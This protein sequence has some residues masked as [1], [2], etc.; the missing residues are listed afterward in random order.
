MLTG[1]TELEVEN[2]CMSVGY[3]THKGG[4]PLSPMEVAQL[5]EK[6]RAHG[7]TT[8]QC[9]REI[10]ID[11][12]GIGRF[13][14][15]LNLPGKFQDIVSWGSGYGAIGFSCANEL[16]RL[17]DS[18]ALEDVAAAI[19]EHGF[20]SRETR[21]VVQLLERSSAGPQEAVQQV[22]RMRPMVEKRYVY[23]GSVIDRELSGWLEGRSQKER[24]KLL[25]DAA[26]GLDL[27]PVSARLGSVRFTVV[28]GQEFGSRLSEIG[29]DPLE[30]MI[31]AIMRQEM[32]DVESAR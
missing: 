13:R 29:G 22:I 2:L 19:A 28:G 5:V 1:L 23:I 9:A 25:A 10:G 27:G 3:R 24:D 32:A 7:N 21:Q 8:S 26:R 14:R 4:R 16:V 20:T 18:P 6:A 30:E 12:T 31:C 11:A 15:L 17:H